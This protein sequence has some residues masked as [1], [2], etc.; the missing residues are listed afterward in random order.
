MEK[1]RGR[2]KEERYGEVGR[3]AGAEGEKGRGGTHLS[4]K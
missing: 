3:Q 4:L 2:G 1:D